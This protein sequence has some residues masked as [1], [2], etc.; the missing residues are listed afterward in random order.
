MSAAGG[1]RVV[2]RHGRATS[3]TASPRSMQGAHRAATPT[4][5]SRGEATAASPSSAGSPSSS[6]RAAAQLG[7]V[8]VPG[9]ERFVRQMIAGSDRHRPRAPRASRPDDGVMPQTERA[10]GRAADSSASRAAWS[11]SRRRDL[12]DDGVGRDHGRRGARAPGGRPRTPYAGRPVVPVSARDGAT[13]LDELRRRAGCRTAHGLVRAEGRAPRQF[14][15]LSRRPRRS[16]SRAS[17]TVVTGTL[18]SAQ[19]APGDELELLPGGTAR[20]ASA[21]STSHGAAGRLR[22]AAAGNRVALNLGGRRH[23]GR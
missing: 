19:L 17:G 10:P 3:T 7:V 4:A 8:D 2:L 12:V 1:R 5:S 16:P 20:R 9:H 13:G 21:P 23:R 22:R 14:R 6:C 11:P 15:T 18:W